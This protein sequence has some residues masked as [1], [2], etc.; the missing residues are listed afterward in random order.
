MHDK[1]N[2]EN[3]DLRLQNQAVR[4]NLT[5]RMRD[6]NEKRELGYWASDSSNLTSRMR[7]CSLIFNLMSNLVTKEILITWSV[8]HN[9]RWRYSLGSV[10]PYHIFFLVTFQMMIVIL[11]TSM[12]MSLRVKHDESIQRETINY[13]FIRFI[14]F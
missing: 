1:S 11:K 13:E 3:K 2:M 14:D 9:M 10:K 8:G 12:R 4:F 5:S 7:M 6:S